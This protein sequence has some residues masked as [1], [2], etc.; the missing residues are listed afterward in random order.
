MS[1]I[2]ECHSSAL[3]A[4]T[5]C[6]G[7]I[8]YSIRPGREHLAGYASPVLGMRFYGLLCSAGSFTAGTNVGVSG[9][10]A[11]TTSAAGSCIL[12]A[13]AWVASTQ[14]RTCA[15]LLNQHFCCTVMRPCTHQRLLVSEHRW[16]E[17]AA[18]TVSYE[19]ARLSL[20]SN[21]GDLERACS[22]N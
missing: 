18:Q 17:C 8:V 14:F 5:A 11:V 15:G 2:L 3:N 13:W 4:G 19:S 10:K 12:H 6:V 16:R 21:T 22:L 20:V 7:D 1:C 9:L